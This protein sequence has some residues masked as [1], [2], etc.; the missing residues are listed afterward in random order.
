MDLRSYNHGYGQLYYHIVTAPKYR[1]DIFKDC[2]IKSACE[3]I[4]REIAEAYGLRK[5]ALQFLHTKSLCDL[6]VTISELMVILETALQFRERKSALHFW[7]HTNLLIRGTQNHLC[8]FP[9]P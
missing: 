4:F 3:R 5:I 7:F 6:L 1:L 8:D 9:V 2:E